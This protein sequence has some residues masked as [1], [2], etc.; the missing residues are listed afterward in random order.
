LKSEAASEALS[1][2]SPVIQRD[3]GTTIGLPEQGLLELLNT[4]DLPTTATQ[5]SH[6]KMEEE[7]TDTE[8]PSQRTIVDDK[9]NSPAF[10]DGTRPPNHDNE[11]WDAPP[12]EGILGDAVREINGSFSALSAKVNFLAGSLRRMQAGWEDLTGPAQLKFESIP[13]SLG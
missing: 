13:T 10:V 11:R 4:E 8:T 1:E 2:A 9:I 3:V 12:F 7:P 6:L 5:P